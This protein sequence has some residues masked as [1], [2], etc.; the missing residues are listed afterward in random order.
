MTKLELVEELAEQ[1]EC[2]YEAAWDF[3]YGSDIVFDE[4]ETDDAL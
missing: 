4:T 2:S 1:F 3:V